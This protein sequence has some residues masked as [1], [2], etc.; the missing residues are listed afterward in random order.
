MDKGLGA[1]SDGV[2]L[3]RPMPA[4]DAGLARAVTPGVVGTKMQPVTNLFLKSG[5]A[6]VVRLQ[7]ELAAQVAEHGPLTF[8]EGEVSIKSPDKAGADAILLDELAKGLDALPAG[9]RVMLK[10]TD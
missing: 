5:I 3:I 2:S 4:L 9:T 8:I 10:L 1:E 6:A 7:F